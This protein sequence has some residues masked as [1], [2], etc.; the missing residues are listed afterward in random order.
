MIEEYHNT[1]LRRTRSALQSIIPV[2]TGLARGVE[3]LLPELEGKVTAKA[4]RVPILNVSAID[5]IAQLE[6]KPL[7]DELN[8]LFQSAAQQK[9]HL[10]GYSD[11]PH[12]YIVFNYVVQYCIF[13]RILTYYNTICMEYI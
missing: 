2:A 3:R 7:R 6:K 13:D 5:L 10:M 9:P 8:A 11:Q 12:A 4:V 1:D